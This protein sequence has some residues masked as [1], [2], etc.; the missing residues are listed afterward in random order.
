MQR[1]HFTA[2]S[3]LAIGL[4]GG[5]LAPAMALA[6]RDPRAQRFATEIERIERA[7]RGRLGVAI[8]D[9]ASGATFAHRGDERFPMCSTFKLLAAGLVL[10][11]VD[12]GEEQ[13]ARPVAIRRADLLSYA[14]ITRTHVGGAMTVAQ[15]CEAAITMSDNTAANLLLRSFGG[16][17]ALTAFLRRIG[18]RVTRLDRIEPQ[19]NEARAGDPRDTTTPS[20]MAAT[21]RRL[22]LGDV[23]RAPSREQ[24]ET[25]LLGNRVGDARLRS[26]LPAGWR[27]AD[28]TGTGEHG[29]S[30]DAGVLMPPQRSPL[31]VAAYLTDSSASAQSRDRA[32]A[33][34]GELAATLV[35]P[36]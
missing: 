31:I 30:N 33:D 7:A 28:K 2:A 22:V 8:V 13:L 36:G 16:P 29:T 9:T 1:R 5:S 14:P 34:I 35:T 10:A 32:L 15:L 3:A 4:A 25:W 12:R 11:R 20:A 18:D 23:L 24:L 26:R 17:A 6:A 27:V 19:L 21:I